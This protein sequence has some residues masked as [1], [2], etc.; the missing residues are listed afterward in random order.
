MLTFYTHYDVRGRGGSGYLCANVYGFKQVDDPANADIII[1]NG[2]EDIATSIYGEKPIHNW[3]P[4]E[5]SRR[6]QSEIDLYNRF[7]DDKSKLFL[8][9]CRGGQLLNVLNGGKLYQHVNKHNGS[10]LMVDVRSGFT[11]STTSVH[12]QQ[13]KPGP[14]AIIIGVSSESTEKAW[15]GGTSY[16]QPVLARH[17]NLGQDV[18]ADALKQGEDLEVIWYPETR[19]LCIQGHPEYAPESKFADYCL[20]LIKEF[21]PQT[22]QAA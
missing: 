15:E 4:L 18:V 5:V 11:L 13:F 22:K 14:G 19:C 12:H 8:G 7:K 9:I 16:H 10:H 1:W 3:S 2:G 6:D 17:S 20:G 21:M